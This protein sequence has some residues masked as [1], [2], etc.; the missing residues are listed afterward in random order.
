MPDTGESLGSPTNGSEPCQ[1][2]PDGALSVGCAPCVCVRILLDGPDR[3]KVSG[4]GVDSWAV[5]PRN[6][7]LAPLGC[8]GSGVGIDEI[9]PGDV[10][11]FVPLARPPEPALRGNGSGSRGAALAICP[12][13]NRVGD[14]SRDR[15]GRCSVCATILPDGRKTELIDLAGSDPYPSSVRP[16]LCPRSES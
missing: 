16:I 9:L 13:G 10:A 8:D 14:P 2:D 6:R 3:K 7:D 4:P 15:V 12:V 11:H 5:S 1:A